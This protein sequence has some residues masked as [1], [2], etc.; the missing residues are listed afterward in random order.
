MFHV[1]SGIILLTVIVCVVASPA[2]AQ[3][4]QL[5]TFSEQIQIVVESDALVKSSVSLLSTNNQEIAFPQNVAD[6]IIEDGRI[7]AVILTNGEECA[8]GVHD[9]LCIL[10]NMFPA[11]LNESSTDI[12]RSV[13]DTYIDIANEAFG[14]DARF[15]SAVIQSGTS[16][17]ILGTSGAV[18][19]LGAIS[20]VYTMPQIPADTAFENISDMMILDDIRDSGGF[21]DIASQMSSR[22]DAGITASMFVVNGGSLNQVRVSSGSPAVGLPDEITPLEYL[23]VDELRRS[24][25]FADGFYPLNSL[26]SVLV[27]SPDPL[28]VS[29]TR[30]AIV[31]TLISDGEKVPVD[32]MQSGWILDPDAG[33]IINARFLFGTGTVASGDALDFALVAAPELETQDPVASDDSESEDIDPITIL[34][35]IL[36]VAV[37]AAFYYTRGYKKDS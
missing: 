12:S 13:A 18:S 8:S 19:G 37:V 14:T 4:P 24:D 32:L 27:I 25:Y 22:S 16:P 15:H 35:T 29:E 11:A 10:I 36:A 1:A 30:S 2:S 26:L 20:V 17:D 5:A 21:Y 31:D 23:G 28:R 34:V 33:E 3:Q 7:S 6:Q 9:Q